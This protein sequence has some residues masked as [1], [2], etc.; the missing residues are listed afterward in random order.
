MSPPDGGV[1][2]AASGG[3]QF[4]VR[5]WPNAFKVW[6]GYLGNFDRYREIFIREPTTKAVKQVLSM[7]ETESAAVLPM[8]AGP[9]A[10]TSLQACA[11]SPTS[12]S[13]IAITWLPPL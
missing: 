1:L 13:P 2:Q 3:G 10:R 7:A 4:A 9:C 12:R 8:S 11:A 5:V 6:L